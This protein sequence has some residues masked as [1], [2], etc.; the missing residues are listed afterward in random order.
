MRAVVCVVS[1]LALQIYGQKIHICN[2]FVENL[3]LIRSVSIVFAFLRVF[4]RVF[5]VG[6][7][8]FLFLF[9]A[10]ACG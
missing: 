6:L 1:L 4:W 5:I 2:F 10:V 9:S 8:G 3:M 7:G